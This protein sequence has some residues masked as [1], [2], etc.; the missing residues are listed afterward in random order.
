MSV[1]DETWGGVV[2]APGCVG[3]DEHAATSRTT[4]TTAPQ[5]ARLMNL[6]GPR[7]GT[8]APP[9]IDAHP[10][11]VGFPDVGLVVGLVDRHAVIVAADVVVRVVVGR[12][13]SSEGVVEGT[14]RIG[15]APPPLLVP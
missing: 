2:G 9:S 7:G 11:V 6:V 1:V 10:V 14:P 13:F 8:G 12:A 5:V 15:V 4:E 3:V